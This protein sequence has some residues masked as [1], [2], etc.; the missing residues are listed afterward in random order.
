MNEF[1]RENFYKKAPVKLIIIVLAIAVLAIGFV[2]FKGWD[3]TINQEIDKMQTVKGRFSCLPPNDVGDG[4]ERGCE[5]GVESR[6]GSYYA[7]DVSNVQDA[8]RD[9]RA[10][11]LIAVTGTITL[12]S[13]TTSEMWRDYDIRGIIHVNTLLRTR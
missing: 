7:L 12:M 5:L 11:D 4:Q 8:N 2:M 9:L 10:E 1:A 6:D 3:R 13:A